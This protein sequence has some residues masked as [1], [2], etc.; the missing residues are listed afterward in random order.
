MVEVDTV[1]ALI[2]SV[3]EIGFVGDGQIHAE[4]ARVM[5][6]LIDAEATL[7]AGDSAE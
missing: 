4:E 2:I 3:L 6:L 1:F 5:D 7:A